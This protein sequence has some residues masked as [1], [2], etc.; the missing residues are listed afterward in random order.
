MAGI[1]HLYDLYNSKGKQ[2]I[3]DL[4]NSFVTVNE[5]M[6]GS[7]FVFERD[8]DSGK[9]VFYKRD[10]RNPITMVDRTLMKYY[11]K[12][13]QH[14][15]S[16]PP[17]IIQ[18][19]PRG[20][21]FGLEYFANTQPVEIAYDRLPK[22][23]LILSYVHP[24]V[25][26]TKYNN[27]EDKE[28]L[29]S[30]A[31]LLGVERPPIVFQGYLSPEQKE[32]ILSFLQTPFEDLVSEYKT[33]SFVR[34]IL[35]VLNPQ[36][37]AS[38]LND[39]LDKPIEG[40]V[41]RFGKESTTDQVL[42][43]MVDPVFTEMAKMKAKKKVQE[44]PSDFLGITILDV[45]NFMLEK[46]V[47][48][49]QVIGD[50]ED[51]RYISFISDVFAKFLAEYGYKYKGADFQE[52][53]YLKKEEFRLNRDLIRD[54]RVISLIE[55]D[56][57]YESLF[58]LILNSFRKIKKRAG[59][60]ITP[61]II[62]QFNLL[63]KDIEDVV[64]KKAPAKIQESE[65]VPSFL[66][67]KKRNFSP[68]KIDYVTDESEEP[69]SGDD[70]LYSF[71]EFISALETIDTADKPKTKVA[72]AAVK[73]EEKPKELQKVNLIVGR[74]QPFHDGHF[75]M[76]RKLMEKNELP[77]VLAVVHPGHNRSGKSPFDE[78]LVAKYMEAL[79][80][81]N[82]GKILGYFMNTRGLLGPIYGR[83]KE[84]GYLP[85]AIGCGDDTVENYKKQSDY[86]KK[87]GGD[88]PKEIEIVET[89]RSLSATKVREL[90]DAE[91][92][93]AFKKSVP[94]AI[95]SFYP[96]LTSALKGRDVKESEIEIDTESVS[97]PE[98]LSEKNMTA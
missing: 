34:Y 69:K 19:I 22:N 48:S 89:P 59:G 62:D 58:K 83:A 93:L 23:N 94:G 21:K 72:K 66:E 97:S 56:E 86:L 38:A 32:Q 40:I 6:D 61:G 71:N 63:V 44:K 5:K 35:G 57:S 49:F 98:L 77:V 12:P 54:K 9:F 87:A 4:F 46:G 36:A 75:K 42:A 17:H 43:K 82:P 25:D 41:F 68:K 78:N 47:E 96:Q 14:I 3:D 18:R 7:A 29:D 92:F 31:D 51:E 84:L 64:G 91:D 24:R 81:D 13:I 74:F 65:S 28:K 55:T 80:R 52:P 53:E 26:D 88:F 1:S 8:P 50:T 95:A 60:I 2:F 76:V 10:Q 20:W 33:R 27:I 85:Q 79:V 15:E 37:K 11:E 45:M 39:D 90:L 30:W 67:F 70:E 73:E 16:L